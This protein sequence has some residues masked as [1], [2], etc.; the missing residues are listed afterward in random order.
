MKKKWIYG[1]CD[2]K[3]PG[4]KIFLMMRL[5]IVFM[6]GAVLQLSAAGFA[7]T[8]QLKGTS[9]TLKSVFDEVERQTGKI[10]LFSN[11]ELDMTRKVRLEPGKCTLESLYHKILE[12]TNLE[13]VVGEEYIVI[14]RKEPLPVQM[15]AVPQSRLIKGKVTDEHKNPLPGVT[16]IIEGT[17]LG[18]ATDVNGQ[19]S[20]KLPKQ[21]VR[22]V[23]TFVGMQNQVVSTAGLD[24]I[25]VV[26]RAAAENLDEVVVVGYSSKKVSEMTGAV[27]QFSGNTVTD[28][29]TGG[30]I[31]DALR[32]HTTGLHITGSDGTPGSDGSLLL[33]GLGTLYSGK[34][35]PLIV[36]DGVITDYTSLNGVIA[37]GDIEN[38]TVLK[39]AAS[40]AIYGSRA[41]TGVIV[42]TTRSG[43]KSAAA[44]DISV[45]YGINVQTFNGIRYRTS[46][47]L[48]EWAE[49]GI[50][51][52]WNTTESL[53]GDYSTAQAFVEDKLKLL[54]ENF[55]LSRTTDWR[56][57]EFRTGATTDVSTSISGGGE[58]L[59]YYFSYSYFDE[60]GT[61]VANSLNRNQ[62]RGKIDFKINPYLSVG[63][64]V[65]GVFSNTKASDVNVESYHPWLSPYNQ[66]GSY[67]YSIP[68]WRFYAMHPEDNINKL[69][70]ARYNNK[71]TKVQNLFGS[72]YVR[73]QP[74]KWVSFTS[75]NTFTSNRVNVN[76]YKDKRTFSA[77]HSNNDI[78]NGTL[79]LQNN[80]TQAFLTSNILKLNY[81]FGNHNLSGL[82]GQEYSQS[83]YWG[84]TTDYYEQLIA[85]ERN[86]GGFAKIGIKTQRNAYKPNG[87][88]IENGSFSVFSELNYN[89]KGK[90]MASASFR[91]D[92]STNFGK[93]NR[94]GKF[95]SVS[96]SWLMTGENFMK[97]FSRLSNLKLRL[98]YGTSGKEAGRDYL[99]YTLY[100]GS[101]TFDYYRNNPLYPSVEA[102]TIEQL[103]NDQLT[104]ETAH[105]LNIGV[106]VG[107]F[108]NRIALSVD[109]YNRI[110][111]ELI[112]R[113]NRPA[114]EGVGSQ[115]RNIGEMRNRGI[116]LI[117]NTHNIKTPDFNWY[118]SFNFSYNDNELKK[119][120]NGIFTRDH[121]PTLY[122]GDNIDV[123]KVVKYMGVNSENGAARF[124][125]V[126]ND[127]S[128]KI[129]ENFTEAI[130]DNGELSY[131]NI[132]VGRAPYF[133]GFT[134][135]FAYKNWELYVHM[136]YN[137]GHKVYSGV[138][139]GMI[140][141]YE[142]VYNNIYMLSDKLKVWEKPG[143]EAD[144]PMMSANTGD[145]TS[146]NL[147]GTTFGYVNAGHAKIQSLRL[148][149][150]LGKSVLEKLHLRSA[151]LNFT[152]DN[153]YTITSRNFIGYDPENVSGW[154][155]PRRFIFGI[156]VGF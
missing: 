55:D 33:R 12:G 43:G 67:K 4:R 78:S 25:D 123:L 150:S 137:L 134:N 37:P 81:S 111:S 3:I 141:N 24:V 143:D 1:Y 80:R 49:M 91:T 138:K 101:S 69:A 151:S 156:N 52:W 153:L 75:T 125:K 46:P 59:N 113:T 155:A 128:R 28:A 5:C 15:P 57:L 107:V 23:F 126:N 35:F 39:D 95:Y 145:L 152:I 149:Y 21:D 133:G 63:A 98:S 27:Q 100:S 16:V 47:E 51:N 146:R 65:S 99:N 140:I 120:D 103:G 86:P 79:S 58:H 85:G 42:V 130:S 118:T 154:C 19:Y 30:N 62:L 88:E 131:Q 56:D 93:D 106:D 11:N 76:D 110:N 119:L 22:L 18:C 104:W 77:N 82:L 116:E 13:F 127:G 117:L 53:H 2:Q 20:L 60:T 36:I 34:E 7:Q 139:A 10:T 8:I 144:I 71:K 54:R 66:E 94:Y 115:Y 44:I 148:S 73:L 41:A 96:A 124:E 26:M 121:R 68:Y 112:M 136:N 135:T 84:E 90:Y 97:E 72:F 122:E 87:D 48:V 31:M 108:N 74:F 61:K 17:Q 70:D 102:A 109:A 45:K 40:T 92:A 132:G 14:K 38:I 32:G 29:S 105:T 9:S 129:V 50:R 89:Y 83:H 64:N 6:L 114:A 142:W 147:S